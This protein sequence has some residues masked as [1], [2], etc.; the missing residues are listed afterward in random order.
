MTIIATDRKSIVVGLGITG[1]S[2]VR[3]LLSQGDQV[4]VV[5][6]RSSPP[7]LEACKREFPQVEVYCGEFDADLL[8]TATRLVIS[9]GVSLEEPAISEA[10]QRG[11]RVTG[12]VDLFSQVAD[13]PIV[14]ITGSN[15]K[16]TVTT[17]LAE[18]AKQAG[19]KVAVGGNLG[20]PVLDLLN[21]DVELYVIELSSFQLETTQR[22]GAWAATILNVSEDHMDRYSSRLAYL[23]AKQRIFRGCRYVIVND[24]DTLSEPLM[25]EGMEPIHF[26]IGKPNIRKFSTM[27][28]GDSTFICYGFDKLLS[29]DDIQ[30]KGL[31]NISN[32]LAALSLGTA[33]GINM[34]SMLATLKLYP[35]LQHRCQWV[36][37]V[38][39]VEYINDSKGTN[40]GATAAA[41]ESFGLSGNGKIVL[42]A[43]GEGKGAD[44]APLAK[45]MA[46]F[47]RSAILFGRD[48]DQ[49][50]TALQG[51]VDIQ[52]VGSLSEAVTAAQQQ[53]QS[54]DTVL[55]SP[56]CASF[57][58][59]RNFEER[60]DVFIA[61]VQQL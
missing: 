55:M 14:A 3:Y 51:A 44:F 16:S 46:E 32:A 28:D 49:I 54:G 5:D 48:A 7:G 6:S 24:D 60:G 26:G 45:V 20:M 61:A 58:M 13:A 41:I 59:F 11:V 52:R 34:D 35:G 4:A 38:N 31:H 22:L 53:A 27:K 29:I 15:G 56:A 43:G 25:V 39:G 19:M 36:R 18:M 9:P 40:V 37:S 23:Q 30:I 57:D 21:E 10:I 50:A 12:D 42:I 47:G 17:L 8:S 1:L 2:C 33:A